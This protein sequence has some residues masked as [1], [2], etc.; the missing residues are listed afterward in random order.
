MFYKS[1]KTNYGACHKHGAKGAGRDLTGSPKQLDGKRWANKLLQVILWAMTLFV[2]GFVV[3]ILQN[4]K[5]YQHH[6]AVLLIIDIALHLSVYNS[7]ICSF[8]LAFFKCY[9]GSYIYGINNVAKVDLKPV[10]Q[11]LALCMLRVVF[12]RCY[13]LVTKEEG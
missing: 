11:T 9:T 3:N 12:K 13:V 1:Y 5:H 8:F 10:E 6:F 2:L 7:S 4:F